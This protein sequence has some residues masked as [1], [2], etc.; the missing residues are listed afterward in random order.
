VLTGTLTKTDFSTFVVMTSSLIGG[1]DKAVLHL[2][3][4]FRLSPTRIKS[5]Q[6]R[7]Q[8]RLK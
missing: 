8:G 5:R 7:W 6:T 4:P 2:I 3:T 1:S